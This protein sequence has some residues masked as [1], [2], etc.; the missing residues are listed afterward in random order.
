[1]NTIC[2]PNDQISW[3]EGNNDLLYLM[4][5]SKTTYG[6]NYHITRCKIIFNESSVIIGYTWE[7]SRHI[8]VKIMS[9]IK[10][11]Y[12]SWISILREVIISQFGKCSI[13]VKD[14]KS[15]ISNFCADKCEVSIWTFPDMS[16]TCR[17]SHAF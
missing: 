6:R 7:M 13:C 3:L 2:C 10:H 4:W 16:N 11:I 8:F 15:T 12:H 1:M 5:A 14:I 17:C 9:V